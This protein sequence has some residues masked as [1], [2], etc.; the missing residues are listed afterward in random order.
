[1]VSDYRKFRVYNRYSHPVSMFV[2]DVL[3]FS[4]KVLAI[5][6]LGWIL[7]KLGSGLMGNSRSVAP[8]T[9]SGSAPD[10]VGDNASALRAPGDSIS[11]A[12]QGGQIVLGKV[13]QIEQKTVQE[14][15]V[16]AQGVV[17]SGSQSAND[18]L[19]TTQ[20][21]DGVAGQAAVVNGEGVA[22][23]EDLTK[24]PDPVSAANYVTLLDGENWIHNQEPRKF[25]VQY[26]TSTSLS[27]MEEFRSFFPVGVSG[28]VFQFRNPNSNSERVYGIVNGVFESIADAQQSIDQ[29]P[30]E[31][32]EYAPFVRRM[33]QVQEVTLI[34]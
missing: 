24:G 11:G 20:A 32:R 30:V 29:M 27:R 31:L 2:L 6:C 33:S 5:A 10:L 9:Q 13:Q 12:G 25:T 26:G 22:K 18:T 16:Q 14:T 34:P 3:A 7:Y 1:M 17:V 19:Q 15:T 4:L 21:A 23:G 28:V 8:V